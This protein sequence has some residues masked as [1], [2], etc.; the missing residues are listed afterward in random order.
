MFETFPASHRMSFASL[1]R[2]LSNSNLYR[3]ASAPGSGKLLT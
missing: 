2:K 3:A 1:P